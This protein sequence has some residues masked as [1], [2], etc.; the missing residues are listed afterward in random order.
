MAWVPVTVD[1]REHY[2]NDE[3]MIVFGLVPMQVG[4]NEDGSAILRDAT[5]ITFESGFQV[6][7]DQSPSE[8]IDLAYNSAL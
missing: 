5:V 3:H 4:V 7:I 2:V 8:F 6:P 1:G